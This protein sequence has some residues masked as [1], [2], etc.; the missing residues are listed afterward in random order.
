V[1]VRRKYLHTPIIGSE[2][3]DSSSVGKLVTA[4]L[5]NTI[6]PGW[7]VRANGVGIQFV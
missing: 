6:R 2:H 5:P 7:V 4:P 3:H 1:I